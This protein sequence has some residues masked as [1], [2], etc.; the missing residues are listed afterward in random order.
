MKIHQILPS[1]SPGDAVSND[2]IEIRNILRKWG[3]NSEIYT[4]HIHPKIKTKG[5]TTY[6]KTRFFPSAIN[7]IEFLPQ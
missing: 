1:M 7:S 3:F 6:K 4:Q 5:Y 2:V